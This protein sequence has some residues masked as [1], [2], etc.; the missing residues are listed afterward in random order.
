MLVLRLSFAVV[1]NLF[2]SLAQSAMAGASLSLESS[3]LLADC[4]N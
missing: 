2:Y 1:M 3:L 4:L